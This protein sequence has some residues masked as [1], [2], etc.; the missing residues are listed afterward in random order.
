MIF[1]RGGRSCL[2]ALV[3]ACIK[4]LG[5]DSATVYEKYFQTL[6]RLI[7]TMKRAQTECKRTCCRGLE[8]TS[9]GKNDRWLAIE[10]AEVTSVGTSSGCHRRIMRAS[11][12]QNKQSRC[13][14]MQRNA[15]GVMSHAM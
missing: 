14:Q 2:R 9:L 11:A 7:E 3:R 6:G 10:G 4:R 1:H 15:P 13:C 12:A 5:C 8:I